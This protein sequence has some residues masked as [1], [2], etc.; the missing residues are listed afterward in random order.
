M[1][2]WNSTNQHKTV[3]KHINNQNF[4]NTS[5]TTR[6]QTLAHSNKRK[7]HERQDDSTQYMYLLC[8]NGNTDYKGMYKCASATTS[9]ISATQ[10][11]ASP[12]IQKK[13]NGNIKWLNPCSL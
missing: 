11:L 13:E 7:I 8:A 12:F 5:F 9:K 2:W 6:Q 3:D 10:L 1:C 4:N